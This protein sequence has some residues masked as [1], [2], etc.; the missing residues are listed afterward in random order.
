[1]RICSPLSSGRRTDHCAALNAAEKEY[2][3]NGKPGFRSV[4]LTTVTK[5][6]V[7]GKEYEVQGDE[8]IEV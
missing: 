6:R 2:S 5:V 1:M 3:S 7:D 4:N 8:L